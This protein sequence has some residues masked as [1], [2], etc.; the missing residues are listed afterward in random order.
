MCSSCVKSQ[1]K[2]FVNR[3]KSNGFYYVVFL[4]MI[5]FNFLHKKV[6]IKN[7]LFTHTINNFLC[8]LFSVFTHNP[9]QL[10]SPLILNK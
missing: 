5:N 3:S 10:L 2:D 9:H 8:Q 6:L 7:T 1:E 4:K